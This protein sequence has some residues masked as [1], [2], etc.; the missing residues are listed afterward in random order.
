[1]RV[2]SPSA[3][4]VRF[5]WYSTKCFHLRGI[6]AAKRGVF[7][8]GLRQVIHIDGI[9]GK[10]GHFFNLQADGFK[11]WRIRRAFGQKSAPD[12]IG[13]I[14][15]AP[16]GIHEA[17]V[18][19]RGS[20]ARFLRDGV[21]QHGLCFGRNIP[22]CRQNH[23]FRQIGPCGH[24]LGAFWGKQADKLFLRGN[25]SLEIVWPSGTIVDVPTAFE[26]IETA[27]KALKNNDAK[28]AT[29][30]SEVALAISRRELLPNI[31]RPWLDEK[32]RLLESIRGRSLR[33][34][35]KALFLMGDLDGSIQIAKDLQEGFPYSTQAAQ[36]LAA[37]L[38]RAGEIPAAFQSIQD[39]ERR[40]ADELG[41]TEST[42]LQ[43]WLRSQLPELLID[44]S[45]SSPKLGIPH[46]KVIQERGLTRLREEKVIFSR[47]FHWATDKG[48]YVSSDWC[49]QT[50]MGRVLEGRAQV[51]FEDGTKLILR[52]GEN[53]HIPPGHDMKVLDD[54]PFITDGW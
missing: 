1:M 5:N 37:A 26:A 30:Q 15:A 48:P 27:E 32:R 17:H 8:A 10:E 12:C 28:K 31:D 7:T 34:L 3:P 23:H 20:I 52:R 29:S 47:R 22:T 21:V 24:T 51:E 49:E 13:Q 44:E 39:F 45:S 16:L 11:P 9:T 41:V 36:A 6:G 38:S 4:Y 19:A 54:K 18:I 53:F 35:S 40:V 50:H 46:R 25:G 43:T 2:P 42:N 14:R 33:A